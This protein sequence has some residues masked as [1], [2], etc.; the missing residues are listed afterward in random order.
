MKMK[1]IPMTPSSI[2]IH[3]AATR[4]SMDIGAA[5][6]DRWHRQVGYFCIGYHYVIRRDGTIEKGRPDD[7]PGA[8]ARGHNDYTLGI[9]LVGGISEKGKRNEDNFTPEQYQALYD[10][11]ETL[12]ER[13]KIDEIIG[14]CDLP[15]VTKTCPNFDVHNWLADTDLAQSVHNNSQE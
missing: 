11:C 7:R 6:I 4:P 5:E 12:T 8:H 2:V 1:Y 10:L 15:N 3:C 13:Y 9:C 14:H